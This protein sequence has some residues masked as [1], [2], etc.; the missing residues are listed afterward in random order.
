MKLKLIA[1][2]ASTLMAGAASAQSFQQTFDG[3]TTT[4]L[5]TQGWSFQQSFGS[6]SSVVSGDLLLTGNAAATFAFT[7][8]TP[9]PFYLVSFYAARLTGF[10][11]DYLDVTFAGTAPGSLNITNRF[12][13]L[14]VSVGSPTPG[15]DPGG[16]L[17]QYYFGAPVTPG[18]YTLRFSNGGPTL[19]SAFVIDTVSI[20]AVPEPGTYALML[21]GL[22]VVGFMARRRKSAAGGAAL[23]QG[24]A[25]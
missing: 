19:G 7:V 23:P 25:A 22:G 11:R 14:P 3:Q 21:A 6:T 4:S 15:A 12:E 2:A 10:D 17:Y 5:Q 20:T 8:S 18:D 13:P 1:L 16:A 9:T 24:A